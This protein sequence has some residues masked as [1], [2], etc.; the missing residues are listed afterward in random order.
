MD[1]DHEKIRKLSMLAAF[2]DG[3]GYIG[4][5]KAKHEQREHENYSYGQRLQVTNTDIR[6]MEWLVENFGGK[7]PKP[8]KDKRE[9][10][11]DK[12]AW[13][14]TGTDSYKLLKLIRPYLIMKYEQADLAIE[15]Y[16]KVTKWHYRGFKK[17]PVHK[18]KLAEELHQRCKE[19]NKK[20]KDDD[21]V[22]IEIR[23]P[24]KIN[25]ET[26]REW[27]KEEEVQ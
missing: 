23:I 15:L 12:Y 25:K 11:K 19:L 14:R 5:L 13:S 20:G 10:R 24:L 7:I 1:D 3:E 18:R 17:M 21:D 6:L 8:T 26:L 9:T 16:E 4:I 27:L 22:N 2:I